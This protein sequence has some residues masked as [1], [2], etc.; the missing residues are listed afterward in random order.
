[1]KAQ[2]FSKLLLLPPP[3]LLLLQLLYY[4]Y[5]YNL[6]FCLA[7]LVF[8][9]HQVRPGLSQTWTYGIYAAFQKVKVK[10]VN[11]IISTKYNSQSLKYN[12]WG[13]YGNI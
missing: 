11:A 9:F 7:G 3:P 12:S 4:Y 10:T 13:R 1:M 6:S 5:Y 2:Q 8:W